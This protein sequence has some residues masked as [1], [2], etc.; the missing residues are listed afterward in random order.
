[1]QKYRIIIDLLSVKELD[2]L[3]ENF[4]SIELDFEVDQLTQ[5]IYFTLEGNQFGIIA[6]VS[7]WLKENFDDQSS[8]NINKRLHLKIDVL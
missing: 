4:K 3:Q 6:S 1:M 7:D 5:S 8:R 2:K